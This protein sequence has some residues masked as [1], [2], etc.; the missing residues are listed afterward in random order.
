MIVIA[1]RDQILDLQ[2]SL[3]VFNVAVSLLGLVEQF[4]GSR[5]CH[6]MGLSQRSHA[7]TVIPEASVQ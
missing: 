2:F 1:Q 5:L 3:S 7:L 6:V 4:G